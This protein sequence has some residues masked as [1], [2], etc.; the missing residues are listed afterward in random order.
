ML[1]LQPS[2]MLLIAAAGI[3]RSARARGEVSRGSRGCLERISRGSG[4]AAQAGQLTNVHNLDDEP[5]EAHDE[6]ARGGR[7]CDG[8]ELLLV[9]LGAARRQRASI[10]VST[11]HRA[12][13]ASRAPPARPR[14]AARLGRPAPPARARAGGGGGAPRGVAQPARA[15]RAASPSL[16]RSR[17]RKPPAASV[18][19]AILAALALLE[20]YLF[21]T[22]W[23]ASLLNFCTG[24]T[25]C[26]CTNDIL[27]SAVP[28]GVT[29]LTAQRSQIP[30]CVKLRRGAAGHVYWLGSRRLE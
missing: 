19:S 2:R 20:S 1:E 10:F 23:Y 11:P 27:A 25:I 28:A 18:R 3:T 13:A 29:T 15:P 7:L 24:S 26:S 8:H 9:G 6:E 16:A 5:D 4:P 14:L 30:T 12:L 21:L 17:C 22:S